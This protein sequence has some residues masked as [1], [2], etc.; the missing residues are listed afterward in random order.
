[1]DLLCQ[2]RCVCIQPKR[3]AG[4]TFASQIN[5]SSVVHPGTRRGMSHLTQT[6][7]LFGGEVKLHR[8]ERVTFVSKWVQNKKSR[9]K[10]IGMN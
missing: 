1:M 9:Q 8:F 3:S 4:L 7:T 10:Y 6:V 2:G 5:R